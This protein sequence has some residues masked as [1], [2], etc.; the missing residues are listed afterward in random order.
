MVFGGQSEN[1]TLFNDTWTWNGSTWSEQAPGNSPAGRI[2]AS[3]VFDSATSNVVLFGGFGFNGILNDTWT[4]NGTSWTQ[5]HPAASPSPRWRAAM[6][7]DPAAGSVV[8]FGGLGPLLPLPFPNSGNFAGRYVDLE[9]LGLD[10]PEPLDE[11]T[12]LVVGRDDLRRG[13]P[14]RHHDGRGDQRSF[15][16]R[17]E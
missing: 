14:D 12:T 11:S 17:G 6:S 10:A 13:V 4:W 1:G 7:D 16:S 8:L 3:M 15:R 9:R 2:G 5:Q